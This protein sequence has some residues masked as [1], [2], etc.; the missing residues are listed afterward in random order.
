MLTGDIGETLALAAENSLA[1]A[2]VRLVHLTGFL[3]P[4][5]VETPED[6]S[7]KEL[8][9]LDWPSLWVEEKY[10]GIRGQIHKDRGGKVRI[11]SRTLDEVTEFPELVKPIAELPGEV[12]LD[13]EILAWR[14]ARPLPFTELQR[15]LGR[16]RLDL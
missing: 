7:N 12:I 16:K 15:R 9:G 13:G 5:P 11:F 10:D 8:A 14:G 3:L 1:R 2:M 4:A 6:L